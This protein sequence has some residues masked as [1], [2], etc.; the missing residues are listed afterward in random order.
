MDQ[1]SVRKLVVSFTSYPERIRFVPDVL[2]CLLAQSRPADRIVLYLSEDQFSRREQDLPDALRNAETQGRLLI[3]WVSGDL[4]PH[5]KYFYAFQ[6]YPEDVVVTVDDD[7]LYAPDLL[8]NLWQAHLEYPGAVVAGRTHLITLDQDGGPGPYSQWIHCT[9]GFEAGPSM[10]LFAVGLGGILYEPGWFPPELFSE[11]SI[12]SLCLEADDLWLKAM[13]LAAGVPVVRMSGPELIRLVPGSQDNA[14]YLSNQNRNRNDLYLSGI[15]KWISERYGK[16]VFREQLNSPAWPRLADYGSL[17]EYLN[18]DK[19]RILIG[20]NSAYD[21]VNA[22]CR[23][24]TE[25]L[26]LSEKR[27]ADLEN[28]IQELRNSLSY[29]LGNRIVTPFSRIRSKLFRK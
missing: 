23:R 12:R 2:S 4:K 29:R 5:K 27:A 25:Q 15:R 24:K 8:E 19:R 9:S 11:D 16:D 13:E 10:Q 6:E 3:R 28:I 14:L 22:A 20:V 17:Y 7:V 21:T 18:H 26:A 1:G